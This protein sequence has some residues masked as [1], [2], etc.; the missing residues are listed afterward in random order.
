METFNAAFNNFIVLACCIARVVSELDNVCKRAL[1]Q[2]LVEDEPS[3]Y[4][5][6]PAVMLAIDHIHIIYYISNGCAPKLLYL[7]T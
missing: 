2:C 6:Y 5:K 3:T 7:K 1:V 4:A